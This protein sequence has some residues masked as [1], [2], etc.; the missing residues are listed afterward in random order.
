MSVGGLELLRLLL[1]T[2]TALTGALARGSAVLGRLR[3][4]TALAAA[5]AAAAGHAAAEV[6]SSNMKVESRRTEQ[7]KKE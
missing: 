6:D 5:A 7:L 4:R 2:A 3:R 1:Q